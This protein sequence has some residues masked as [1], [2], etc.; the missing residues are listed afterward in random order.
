VTIFRNTN[1]S[2]AVVAA[3]RE[4]IWQVLT[5]PELLPQLTPLL[6]SIEADG[7]TWRWEMVRISALGVSIDPSFTETMQFTP[8]SRIEY[9]HTPPA[10][11]RERT[12]AEGWYRLED[13]PDGTLLQIS[14][15]LSVDLPLPRASGLA[16]RGV[17]KTMMDRTGDR[18]GK[19][20]QR[21]LGISG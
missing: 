2:Q 5:D 3:P 12:G 4:Q 18:F 14:L 6:R 13:A 11:Q 15:T 8:Q 16:V 10:G 1:E 21:H 20:L 19:N 7:D 9:H 17:M